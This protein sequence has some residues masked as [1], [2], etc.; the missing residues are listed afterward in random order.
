MLNVGTASHSWPVT[1]PPA[2]VAVWP[3]ARVGPAGAELHPTIA[4]AKA[5][6]AI[7][8]IEIRT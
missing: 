2:G 4:T 8:A 7:S 1:T 6:D 3:G 5:A